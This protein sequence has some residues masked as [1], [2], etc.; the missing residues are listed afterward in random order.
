MSYRADLQIEELERENERLI[1]EL[2]IKSDLLAAMT[3]HHA[4]DHADHQ[5]HIAA[6]L[7]RIR[8]KAEQW[9]TFAENAP[10]AGRYFI[11]GGSTLTSQQ[12]GLLLEKAEELH[13]I[14]DDIETTHPFATAHERSREE[15][16]ESREP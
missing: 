11:T 3:K 16:N 12:K 5:R 15:A 9:V 1:K 4:Q 6:I 8:G 2:G 13:K 10:L 14:A 7:L